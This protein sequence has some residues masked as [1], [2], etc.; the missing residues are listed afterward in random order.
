MCACVHDVFQ[1]QMAANYS[2]CYCSVF[3]FLM[4]KISTFSSTFIFKKILIFGLLGLHYC[5]KFSLVVVSGDYSWLRCTGFSHCSA[6]SCW[7]AQAPGARASVAAAPRL[8]SGSTRAYLLRG[9]VRPSWTRVGLCPLHWEAVS[10]QL[11]HQGSSLHF[12][13]MVVQYFIIWMHQPLK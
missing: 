11:C 3:H 1:T 8:S 9:T 7:R 6:F 4:L 2:Y 13:L 10:Y 5:S 12:F